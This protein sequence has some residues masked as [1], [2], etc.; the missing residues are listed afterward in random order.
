MTEKRRGAV[1]IYTGNG[2]GKTTAALGLAL[3][4]AGHDLRT[5]IGQFLKGHDYGE[6]RSVAKLAP[7]ITIAQF[8]RSGFVHVSDPPDARD[9]RKARVGLDECRDA[10]LSGK[11]HVVILDEICV[12]LYFHLLPLEDV[13]SLLDGKP[14]D[15]EL[16]L[17]GRYAPEPL[18]ERA[19][20]V[21]EMREIKHYYQ[22][23]YPARDGI[24]K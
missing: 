16:I 6:L 10:M 9:V 23:G 12:A 13:L 15:V 17:T 20:L 18:I 5:Y 4:A 7:W 21:T 3:R 11:Y 1:Q 22:S 8:G 19:D 24:E 14:K 2:K